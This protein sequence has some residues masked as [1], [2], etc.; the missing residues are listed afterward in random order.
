MDSDTFIFCLEAVPDIET[1]TVTEVVKNLEQLAFEQGITSIYKTCDTIEGLEESLNTLLYDD[2]NFTNYE[3]IYLVMQGEGNNICLNEYYYSLEEIAELFEGKMKGKILHFANAKVLDLSQEEAQYFLDITG[4]RAVSGY[5][6]KF[7]ALT[8]SNL[9]K[10]FFSLF[11]ELD[12]V[13]EIVEE[14]YQ[15]HYALCKL[16]DFRL[17]Y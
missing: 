16:L 10:A 2:H 4:A 11:E 1:D 6:A 8:S 9:D 12:D 3:I 5:G 7:N 17:Y 15:K 14:L 13:V